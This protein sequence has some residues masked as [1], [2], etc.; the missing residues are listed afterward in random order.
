V[1][2]DAVKHDEVPT[3]RDHE[4]PARPKRCGTDHREV[5]DAAMHDD[6]LLAAMLSA[7]KTDVCSHR[8]PTLV[9]VDD[10]V[11]IIEDARGRDAN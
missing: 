5:E 6:F 10:A 3:S 4:L 1:S 7:W 11:R 2:G 9:T 8:V